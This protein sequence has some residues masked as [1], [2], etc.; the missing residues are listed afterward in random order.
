MPDVQLRAHHDGLPGV[1]DDHDVQQRSTE[2]RC[3]V[4]H[5]RVLWL[6]R[7]E[8]TDLATDAEVGDPR[9]SRQSEAG[10]LQGRR[11]LRADYGSSG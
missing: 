9:V 7:Q 8:Q 11:W 3:A 1:G 6:L 5:L 4:Q 2:H 10:W